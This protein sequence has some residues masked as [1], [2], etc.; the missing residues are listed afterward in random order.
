MLE[1]RFPPYITPLCGY[2][3]WIILAHLLDYPVLRLITYLQEEEEL[4]D[5]TTQVIEQLRHTEM[6][7][8]LLLV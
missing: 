4:L 8:G 6:Y 7:Y 2:C 5:K 1:L 3:E